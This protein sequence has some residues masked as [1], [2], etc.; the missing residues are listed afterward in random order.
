MRTV[1]GRAQISR[2]AVVGVSGALALPIAAVT[3]SVSASDAWMRGVAGIVTL[4]AIATTIL[5][6]GA[7]WR[8]AT[9]ST[10]L[11]MGAAGTYLSD[12]RSVVSAGRGLAAAA[13][14]ALGFGIVGAA[15]HVARWRAHGR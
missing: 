7:S 14:M 8:V 9:C 6:A 11:I 2:A 13:L 12:L 3:L 1:G 4:G 5:V 10:V 15:R